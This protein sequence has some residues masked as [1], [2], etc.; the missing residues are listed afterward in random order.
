VR[1]VQSNI[2][3]AVLESQRCDEL[4]LPCVCLAHLFQSL[5]L[6]NVATCLA[7]GGKRILLS[8]DLFL[9]ILYFLFLFIEQFLELLAACLISL[10]LRHF[11]LECFGLLL[12]QREKLLVE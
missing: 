8:F 11:L 6:V 9:A 7:S 10:R 2:C 4:F 3:L 12:L 1:Y 5:T